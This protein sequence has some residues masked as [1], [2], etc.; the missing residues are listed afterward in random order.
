MTSQAPPSLLAAPLPAPAE[1]DAFC[2]GLA[3]SFSHSGYMTSLTS[4]QENARH[5][6]VRHVDN[7]RFITFRPVRAQPEASAGGVF[8][9][10]WQPSPFVRRAPLL[11]HLPGYGAGFSL[12]P[13]AQTRGYH[14]MHV[15]PLGY[16]TPTGREAALQRDGVWPV[17]LETVESEGRLG[18]RTMLEQ[19]LA[20]TA[21][22][23]EQPGVDNTA[24]GFFGTSQGGGL[25]LLAASI[26]R[27]RLRSVVAAHLPFL[28]SFADAPDGGSYELAKK[29]LS[30]SPRP[31]AAASALLHL[32]TLAHAHRLDMPVLLTTG[33]QDK[34][35]PASSARKLFERLPGIRAL[36]ETPAQG[37]IYTPE[38]L[39]LTLTWFDLYL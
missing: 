13:D 1:I 24:V 7:Q 26:L 27:G 12:L 21:W 2:A 36:H 17:M 30:R 34:L 16:V 23:L 14:V 15:S 9:V 31:E 25:S 8:H 22:A 29:A 19:I 37:H 33:G 39:R 35:C 18:Y 38:A 4:F 20:A 28:T 5:I 32:D 6:A 10:L 3:G 11:V